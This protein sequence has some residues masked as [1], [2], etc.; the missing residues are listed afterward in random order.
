MPH[1]KAA[2]KS[3]AQSTANST[4]ASSETRA[5]TAPV[6]D[7]HATNGRHRSQTGLRAQVYEASH[8]SHSNRAESEQA[9]E[10]ERQK[11][12]PNCVCG[13]VTSQV[14]A[15]VSG[16]NGDRASLDRVSLDRASRAAVDLHS[17][18][19]STHVQKLAREGGGERRRE[20]ERQQNEQPQKL[21]H[22]H[23]LPSA[24]DATASQA[25]AVRYRDVAFNQTSLPTPQYP[26]HTRMHDVPEGAV[27]L[28]Q[29]N[30][31]QERPRSASTMSALQSALHV[32]TCVL[33]SLRCAHVE[34]SMW[35]YVHSRPFRSLWHF[36]PETCHT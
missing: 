19:A 36:T 33:E 14:V 34:D 24:T 22:D 32:E 5:P 31:T 11:H 4:V 15:G 12:R 25:A 13:A 26:H 7:L 17:S 27:Q 6:L 1:S 20:G 23:Q 9:R 21:Q 16:P 3:T 18:Y 10:Q 29:Q 2:E 35:Q 30:Q 8:P 28:L